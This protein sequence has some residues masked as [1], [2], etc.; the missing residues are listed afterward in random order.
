MSLAIFDT[1]KAVRLLQEKGLSKAAAEGIAELLRDV[2]ENKLVSR[3]DL[4]L[5]LNAQ[6]VTLIKWIA[7]VLVAHC[8]GTAALT[9]SLLQLLS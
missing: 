4:R 5:A 2:T 3:D 9:V 6:S 8:V 1:Y 7:S